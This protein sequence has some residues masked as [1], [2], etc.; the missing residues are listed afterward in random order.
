MTTVAKRVDLTTTVS[1]VLSAL[2]PSNV[3][4]REC[5]SPG[6]PALLREDERAAAATFSPRRIAEFAAGR[7]CARQAL[8]GAGGPW[9]SILRREDRSP[10]WP[11]GF[12][13]SITHTDGFC[14]A[15]VAATTAYG[16]IGID[17]ER[18]NRLTIDVWNHVF[19]ATENYE[20]MRLAPGLRERTAIVKFSAKEAFY[21]CQWPQ[22]HQWID[23][24]EVAVDVSFDGDS[25]GF[26][27][28]SPQSNACQRRFDA[29]E[30][31]GRF[32]F[33][34]VGFV[35]TGIAAVLGANGW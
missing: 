17:A 14:G 32:V 33:D 35:V 5:R 29:C 11:A 13:G 25:F 26:F 9:E 24:E 1:P 30:L 2:F 7:D 34:P 28:I 22:T 16:S 8:R 21:K 18:T 23:F 6:S 4:T 10:R 27:D 3:A 19:T 15:V 12:T 31:H 20:L